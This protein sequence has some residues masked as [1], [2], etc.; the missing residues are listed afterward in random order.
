MWSNHSNLWSNLSD[1]HILTLDRLR[2]WSFVVLVT[3]LGMSLYG[4]R[5][6]ATPPVAARFWSRPATFTAS[7]PI[8]VPILDPVPFPVPV[9][10][11]VPIL[12]LRRVCARPVALPTY[13]VKWNLF[14]AGYKL[15]H[16]NLLLEKSGYNG[17]AGLPDIKGLGWEVLTNETGEELT[18]VILCLLRGSCGSCGVL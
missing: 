14:R 5:S 15:V 4:P 17:R 1:Y 18:P 16:K 3:T 6:A 2:P 11:L 13:S 12:D 9:P 7:V 10:I 8:P